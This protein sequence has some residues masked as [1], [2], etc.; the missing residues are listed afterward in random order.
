MGPERDSHEIMQF[1]ISLWALG[2]FAVRTED[3]LFIDSRKVELGIMTLLLLVRSI[4]FE[5][6]PVLVGNFSSLIILWVG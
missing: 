1:R 4:V 3:L 5:K 6:S 2:M